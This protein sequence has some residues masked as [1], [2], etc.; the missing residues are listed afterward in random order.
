M[1]KKKLSGII[2]EIVT[3]LFLLLNGLDIQFRHNA[4]QWVREVVAH[5]AYKPACWV[6]FSM[7]CVLGFGL[8]GKENKIKKKDIQTDVLFCITE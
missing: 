5:P 7:D 1:D 3:V 8:S 2:A 6:L 4:R